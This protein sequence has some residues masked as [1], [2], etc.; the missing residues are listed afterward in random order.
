MS[1]LKT[2]YEK[3]LDLFVDGNSHYFVYD[4]VRQR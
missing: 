2:G 1:D 3:G 4:K